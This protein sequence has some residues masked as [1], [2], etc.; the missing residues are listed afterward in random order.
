MQQS[1]TAIL[2]DE[3][4]AQFLKLS[5][6]TLRHHRTSGGD[7]IPYVRIGGSIRYRMEDVIAYLDSKVVANGAI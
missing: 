6:G 2:T 1:L 7:H 5:P 3:E 4:L